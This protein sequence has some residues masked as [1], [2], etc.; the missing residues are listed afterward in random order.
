MKDT[1]LNILI[2]GCLNGNRSDQKELYKQYVRYNKGKPF[3]LL[4]SLI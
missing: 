2:E 1:V 3:P 4:Y